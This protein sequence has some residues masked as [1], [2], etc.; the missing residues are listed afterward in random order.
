MIK[1]CNG[2]DLPFLCLNSSTSISYRIEYVYAS[3][4]H[5][6]SKVDEQKIL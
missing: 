2:N 5:L 4:L 1:E 6:R 3:F